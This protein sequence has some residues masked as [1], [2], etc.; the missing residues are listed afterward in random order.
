MSHASAR[1]DLP[2]LFGVARPLVG[3]IHLPPLPGA[4][5][6]ARTPGP[7][8]AR[9]LSDLSALEQG[10]VDAVLVENYGDAPFHPRRVPR[11]TLAA[12][13]RVVAAVVERSARPVGVNVLRNDAHSAL[14]IA[15]ATGARFI[16]VNV[17]VGAMVTDQGWL[18][19]RAHHTVR[20]R[21]RTAPD[22]AILADVFVKHAAPPPGLTLERAAADTWE[23]GHADAL[24][25]SG[26]ATGVGADP[27]DLERL[28]A[29]VPEAPIW[30][31]SGLSAQAAAAWVPWIDGA[32][33]GSALQEG[34]RAGAPVE[35]SRVASLRDA[36]DAALS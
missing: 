34:G 23:R 20:M 35:P 13:T 7:A 4:P 31:G 3:M 17:H 15:A 28:R 6:A 18:E 12:L 5:G 16:R 21:D 29:A 19:G 25:L 30:L 36:W 9:A 32:I 26:S 22:V 10:G 24:V 8:L 11:L 33:V 14:A 27:A 1:I 2:S